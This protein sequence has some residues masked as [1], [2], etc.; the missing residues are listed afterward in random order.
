[1]HSSAVPEYGTGFT[2]KLEYTIQGENQK[3]SVVVDEQL[4]K[5]EAVWKAVKLSIASSPVLEIDPVCSSSVS[6]QSSVKNGLRNR[7]LVDSRFIETGMNEG[8]AGDAGEYIH[9]RDR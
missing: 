9:R 2:T 5:L 8:G 6:V 7:R 4:Q 3:W 1:M